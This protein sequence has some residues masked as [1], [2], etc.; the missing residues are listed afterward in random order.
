MV[1][2]NQKGRV[3]R[4]SRVRD[5]LTKRN[6]SDGAVSVD[7]ARALEA[8]AARRRNQMASPKGVADIERI[9]RGDDE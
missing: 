3:I 8:E 6:V 4:H 1:N 2:T 9:L 5:G 7:E